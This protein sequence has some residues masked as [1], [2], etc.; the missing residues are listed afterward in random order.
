[1]KHK[2]LLTALLFIPTCSV[3]AQQP[4]A[5]LKNLNMGFE[6]TDLQNGK[7]R[8]W[9]SPIQGPDFGTDTL[10]RHSGK[11]S[12]Y[13]QFNG[14]KDP[15]YRGT[16]LNIYLPANFAGKSIRLSGY[17]KTE[18]ITDGF[19]GLF[20]RLDA[21][22]NRVLLFDSMYKKNLHGT[23]DWEAY[24]I[25]LPLLDDVKGL[26]AG[27]VLTG[28]GKVWVDDL[29]LTIDGKDISKAPVKALTILDTDK[30][31]DQS[32]LISLQNLSA[33]K[34]NDLFLLGKIWGFLKYYH[35]AVINGK[36][37]WD[38]ELFRLTPKLLAATTIEQ[39][40][41][42]ITSWITGLGSFPLAEEKTNASPLLK[43]SPDLK[44]LEDPELGTALQQQLNL[45]KKAKRS[46]DGFYV[47]L[48]SEEEPVPI[49]RNE[50]GYESNKSV[51]D[52]FRLLALY[53]FW[54]MI[55]YFF[56]YK[57]AIEK[58]WDQVL[59][60][61]ISRFIAADTELKYKLGMAELIAE[62]HDSHADLS[63]GADPVINHFYGSQKAAV[64]IKFVDAQPVVSVNYDSNPNVQQMLKAGDVITTVNGVSAALLIKKQLPYTS[65]SNYPTQ[66]RKMTSTLLRT[67]DTALR[68][69]YLRN[70]KE[71]SAVLPVY[72]YQRTDYTDPRLT[73]DT[74]FKLIS[75]DVA[76]INPQNLVVKD[77]PLMMT[78]VMPCKS[79]IIDM[80]CYPRQ[81]SVLSVMGKYLYEKT[82]DYI[83]F[84]KSNISQ[85]GSF[86]YLPESYLKNVAIGEK[87]KDAYRGKVFILI[88]ES[89]QSF[90]EMAAMALRAIPN[91]LL[92]GSQ[93]AGA[94]GTVMPGIM[95]P[96]SMSFKFTG[97]GVYYLDGRETQRIGI[98]PDIE[99]KPT[100]DGIRTGKDEIL[101]RAISEALK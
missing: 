89:T 87:R 35:P 46:A 64:E 44:W 45:V 15:K 69:N 90:A 57:Y 81:T 79:L 91:S 16:N 58:N 70:G 5:D 21:E 10:I 98:V 56:P 95:L 55:E 1:M 33:A 78:S 84:T 52:G 65:A 67:N 42:L 86:E 74:C 63:E 11:R 34:M 97:V 9:S 53:R 28:K 99:V 73:T 39:R 83:R 61:Y 71:G 68:I 3:F 85:P 7:P 13:L 41:Q 66:L 18:G 26:L 8:Y 94:D 29:K 14:N 31:F 72:P 22:N 54:N 101:E 100:L 32:S 49:F 47:K 75:A 59:K 24:S 96:G 50:P 6:E 88:N 2:I 92:I 4:L 12:A 30:E 93:T 76:Y 51:D 20:L 43:S 37:N 36:Y 25:E 19:A 80:R 27:V 17:V 48:Y 82:T 77:I 23:H 62:I 60:T 40:N 38:Y